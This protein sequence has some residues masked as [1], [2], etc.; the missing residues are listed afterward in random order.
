MTQE[1]TG[2]SSF[3]AS[4]DFTVCQQVSGERPK[5]SSQCGCRRVSQKVISSCLTGPSYIVPGV[6]REVS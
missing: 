6:K 5:L 1:E 2:N 4:S 3:S